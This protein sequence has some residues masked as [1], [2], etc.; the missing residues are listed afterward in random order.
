MRTCSSDGLW[1][2]PSM[3]LRWPGKRI[4]L[5]LDN[6]RYHKTRT[7]DYIAP[8]AKAVMADRL[9]AEGVQTITVK[10]N[11]TDVTIVEIQGRLLSLRR[12]TSYGCPSCPSSETITRTRAYAG[13]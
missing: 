12:I 1:T 10:R 9:I 8:A 4:I 5:V 11:G 7:A 13:N 3:R 2:V 6:A